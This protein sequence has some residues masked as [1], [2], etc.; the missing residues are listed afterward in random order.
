MV[1]V[2]EEQGGERLRDWRE[3]SAESDGDLIVVAY[4]VIDGEAHDPADRLGVE[5]QQDRGDPGVPRTF[6]A[7]EQPSKHGQPAVLGQ[8]CGPADLDA[9]ELETAGELVGRRPGEEGPQDVVV[10]VEMVVVNVARG[11]R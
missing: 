1:G 6:V 4:N 10:A 2:L 7:G 3:R 8:R 9:R 11:R 5:Q